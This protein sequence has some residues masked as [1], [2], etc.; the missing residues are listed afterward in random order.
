MRLLKLQIMQHE[1]LPDEFQT[2]DSFS[3][4]KKKIQR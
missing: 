3:L 4:V 2:V 1:D